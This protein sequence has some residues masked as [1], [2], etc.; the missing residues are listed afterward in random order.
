MADEKKTTTGHLQESTQHP[1]ALT[2][3]MEHPKSDVGKSMQ[4]PQ[5]DK[6]QSQWP[7]VTK[8]PPERP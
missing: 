1:K 4:H 2:D 6:K 5:P 3:S 7:P 8:K